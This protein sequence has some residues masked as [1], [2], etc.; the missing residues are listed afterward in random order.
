MTPESVRIGKWATSF[1]HWPGH[2]VLL[3]LLR[4]PRWPQA[5]GVGLACAALSAGLATVWWQEDIESLARVRQEVA[6]LQAVPPASAAAAVSAAPLQPSP[7]SPAEAVGTVVPQETQRWSWL[8]QGLQ[9]H[10][11]RVLAF[12]P[13][14]IERVEGRR[15]Q[16]LVL[17]VQGPWGDWRAFEQRLHHEA[18]GWTVRQWQVVP[19]GDAGEVRMQWHWRWAWPEASPQPPAGG[20]AWAPWRPTP[21]TGEPTLFAP[22]GDLGL[23]ASRA[24]SAAPQEPPSDPLARPALG[25]DPLTWPVQALRLHG[26]WFQD[27]VPH[28]VLGQGLNLTR[29]V[30]GQRVGDEGHR[31]LRVGP[32]VVVLQ[33]AQPGAAPLHLLMKGE[34]P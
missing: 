31:V 34:R 26:V 30:P 13:G 4:D 29:V 6:A 32:D 25:P 21:P 19:T 20:Q 17:E 2:E 5:L 1:G 27:G 11:L 33:P 23:A 8:L 18:A 28:A 22:S 24:R 3:R 12:R 14:P 10:G 15:E 9:A 7:L 16:T